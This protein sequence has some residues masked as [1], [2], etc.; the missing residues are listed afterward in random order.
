MLALVFTT[1][2]IGHLLHYPLAVALTCASLGLAVARP[3]LAQGAG[4]AADATPTSA[5]ADATPAGLSEAE[6]KALAEGAAADASSAPAAPATPQATSSAALSNPALS[7]IL[8]TALA[9][10]SEGKPLLTGGHDPKRNGFNLQQLE[11]HAESSVDPYLTLQANIVFAQFGVEVEEMYA[12]SLA[13]PGGLQ[14]KAGQFLN[15]FGRINPTHLHSWSFADQPLMIGKFFG[16]EGS[17]GLGA[18]LGWLLPLPW[19][20]EIK[21][22]ATDAVGACCARSLLGG[23]DLPVRSPADVAYTGNLK[24]FLPLDEDWSLTLSTSGQAGPNASGNGNRSEILGGD[25][26]LRYRP[27]ADPE[28]RHLSLQVEHAVRARQV[29]GRSL[30]DH[31]GYA[32]L[33]GALAL[34]WELGVRTEWTTGVAGDPLDPD[35]TTNRQRHAAQLTFYPSHFSRVRVQATL[36]RP[37]WRSEPIWGAVVAL[38]ALIGAHGSHGF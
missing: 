9:G 34:R 13:L 24:T 4:P 38:E 1:A 19:Y 36:D 33:V 7:L 14:L 3:A 29:P 31:A 22:A 25:L 10:Y 5:A 12:E 21:A 8:D 30:V 17:R 32:Q 37:T 6:L 18:Q 2:Q 15:A 35:W 27:V 16:S 20:V 11:L 28:R 26:Y 23:N